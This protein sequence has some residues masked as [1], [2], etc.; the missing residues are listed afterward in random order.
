MEYP[1]D[2]RCLEESVA[3]SE[4]LVGASILLA[5]VLEA[6]ERE[7]EVYLPGV[8]GWYEWWIEEGQDA[9]SFKVAGRSYTVDVPLDRLPIYVAEGAVIPNCPPV[10]STSEA[11]SAVIS[12]RI[13]PGDNVNGAL[14]IDDESTFD[15]EDGAFSRI[16][17][18]GSCR[19]TAASA[20]E[21]LL[22][23]DEGSLRPPLGAHSGLVLE[24]PLF[25]SAGVY[26]SG[27]I[28]ETFEMEVNGRKT[29][30]RRNGGWLRIDLTEEA[31]PIRIALGL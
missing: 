19:V 31:F 28:G 14:Y 29:E 12:L 23:R 22:S 5:P 30:G 7:R 25:D 16:T 10:L 2:N 20:I 11:E 8:G 3:H 13:Y 27:R 24:L 9:P 15:Y 17:I 6:G 1:G 21:L 26:R 4:L 18:S